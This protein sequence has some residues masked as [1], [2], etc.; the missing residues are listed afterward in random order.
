MGRKVTDTDGNEVDIDEVVA[1]IIG[2][3]GNGDAATALSEIM[4]ENYGL[5]RKNADLRTTNDELTKKAIPEGSVVLSGDDLKVWETYKTLG[6]PEDL[7]KTIDTSKELE[8]KY[9]TLLQDGIIRDAAASLGYKPTVLGDLVKVRGLQVEI[10]EVE[11][12][13]NGN[14]VKKPTPVV[15]LES[16]NVKPLGELITENFSDYLPA[17]QVEATPQ[18]GT[19]W[20]PQRSGGKAPD[21]KGNAASGLLDKYTQQH[22]KSDK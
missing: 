10:V 6:K 4:V 22:V 2:T 13:D 12:E 15:K 3:K 18:R 8:G 11:T 16:G 21:Q 14:K 9:T 20:V 7:Q 5:R 1:K 19:P 17:L